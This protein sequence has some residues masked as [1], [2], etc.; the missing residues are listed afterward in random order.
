MLLVDGLLFFLLFV[1]F[2]ASSDNASKN[3]H[4]VNILYF[5]FYILFDLIHVVV[6]VLLDC[7]FENRAMLMNCPV[8]S[9]TSL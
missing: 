9:C 4:I 5:C 8:S 7:V 1:I 3:V 6:C 2:R